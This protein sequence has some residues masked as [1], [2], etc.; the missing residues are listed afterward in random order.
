MGNGLAYLD[1]W[2]AQRHG[3]CIRSAHCCFSERKLGFAI[4]IETLF[5]DTL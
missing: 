5:Q 4:Q 2:A 1:G 3:I